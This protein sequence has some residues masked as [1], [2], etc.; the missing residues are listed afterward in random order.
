MEILDSVSG[1]K[2][3]IG[4]AG[5]FGYGNYGDEL[6]LSVFKEYLSDSFDLRILTDELYKPYYHR[7]I[8][9]I[10]DEVDAIIIGGGDIVQ[11]WGLDVR[12][13]SKAFLRK[14]VFIIGVGVP[15]RSGKNMNPH[16]H[17]K[18]WI[19]NKYKEFFSHPSVKM[20][21][22]RDP[23]SVNWIQKRLEPKIEVREDPDIVCALTLPPAP[24]PEGAPILGI[25][26]RQRPDKEDDYSH[27]NALA[28]QQIDKGWEIHHIVLGS[29]DVG[30]RDVIDAVDVTV[31][32]KLVTSEN[33]EAL[34]KAIGQCTAIVSMKFHGTVVATMYGVP[35]TVLIPTNKNR[36]FMNRIERGELLSHHDSSDLSKRF[37]TAPAPIAKASIAMLRERATSVMKD[38]QTGLVA[39]LL[40]K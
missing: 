6:F 35:S 29:G 38:L 34:S 4:L 31:G 7:P 20:I 33:C 24:K 19:I 36:N 21:H 10:V 27:I 30:K 16:H 8:E 40:K 26:T 11:P 1:K 39:A 5:F 14:P 28:Q 32:K 37:T 2:P 25:V 23:Q 17:E 12:Y 9:E 22:A 3:I 18:D 15:I 13:F